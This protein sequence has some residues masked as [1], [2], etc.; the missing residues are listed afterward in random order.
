MQKHDQ[1][2]WKWSYRISFIVMKFS[3]LFLFKLT[4]YSSVRAA[5]SEEYLLLACKNGNKINKKNT[6]NQE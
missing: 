4:F 1:T 5:L 6:G 2:G 3:N